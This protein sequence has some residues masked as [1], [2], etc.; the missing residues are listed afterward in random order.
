MQVYD[1][2]INIFK[3]LINE[4]K[5]N[6]FIFSSNR[7][8]IQGYEYDLF[9]R[10]LDL[11]IRDVQLNEN[12]EYATEVEQLKFN[13]GIGGYLDQQKEKMRKKANLLL[14]K[15]H[16][17]T[18]INKMKISL[19]IDGEEKGNYENEIISYGE[20]WQNIVNYINN[21]YFEGKERELK[22]SFQRIKEKDV[23]TYTSQ[24]ICLYIKYYKDIEGDLSKIDDLIKYLSEWKEEEIDENEQN[25]RE[26][27]YRY[28][29]NNRFSLFTKSCDNVE[30]LLGE[31]R[32]IKD[33][34]KNYFP[35]YKFIQ[36]AISLLQ[37]EIN[38][39]KSIKEIEGHI[40]YINDIHNKY[41][42]NIEWSL[43]HSHFIF[44][45]SLEESI[46]DGIFIYSSFVLPIPN[47]DARDKYEQE[48][49]NFNILKGQIEPLKKV[50]Q[51]LTESKQINEELKKNKVQVIE[52]MGI[53]LAVIAF[54]MSSIS[55]FQFVTSILSAV[56]FLAIFST[57]LI[58]FLLVLL[59]ITRYNE[60]ILKK[61]K[62][63]I[64]V[65]Y[66]IKF[67]LIIICAYFLS[68]EKNKDTN[69]NVETLQSVNTSKTGSEKI[70]IDTIKKEKGRN[71]IP[72]VKLSY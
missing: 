58:S 7:K 14:F 1:K 63:T 65:F 56:L 68:E 21:H 67:I 45:T 64:I 50:N 6:I 10:N 40:E 51:L 3:F 28:A 52:L 32:K 26:T 23:K 36:R 69:D 72:S 48:K 71:A 70:N 49:N 53:F 29:I 27:I 39:N 22:K 42:M 60:N 61:Y 8:N 12:F 5:D 66:I 41:K 2:F 34:N 31:Y 59:L 38:Q 33:N 15:W 17:L 37:K 44:R 57:S 25:V 16:K 47:K 62:G 18:E 30:L 35:Q 24:E 13:I 46:I 19:V 43:G 9:L 4:E 55:G 54:V 11:C 20:E